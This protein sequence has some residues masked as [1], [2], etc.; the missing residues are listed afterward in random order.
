MRNQKEFTFIELIL[1]IG[2]LGVLIIIATPHFAA[3][4]NYIYIES[5]KSDCHLAASLLEMYYVDHGKYP[6]HPSVISKLS[7]TP[8]DEFKT[9]PHNSIVWHTKNEATIIIVKVSSTKTKQ[10]ATYTTNT[11]YPFVLSD[12][13]RKRK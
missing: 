3:Y 2:I 9:S 5:Q 1:S 11:G 13:E 6:N 7:L 10:T 12:T 4:Q 8:F